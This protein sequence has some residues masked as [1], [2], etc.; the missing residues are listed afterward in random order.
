VQA[1]ITALDVI[2]LHIEAA[3]RPATADDLP[4]LEWFGQYWGY[5]DIFQ[6]TYQD[7]LRG[8]RLM[9]VADGRKR[10]Y[11]YA[12][13]VM[14]PFQGHGLGTRLIQAAEAAMLARGCHWATIAVAKDNAGALRLYE[15]LGYHA[16]DDDP[17]CWS[18]ADPDGRRHH[19]NEPSWI[20][21]KQLA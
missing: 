12:L 19:V 18:Y 20:M 14:V 5:R 17:G 11:I 9:L 3:I 10:A 2:P 15:R 1:D 7:H 16:F 4:R 21:H 13:R 8:S 6:R